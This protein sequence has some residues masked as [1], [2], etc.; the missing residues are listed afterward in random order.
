MTTVS[1]R[2][3]GQGEAPPAADAGRPLDVVVVTT[4][5]PTPAETF[6]SAR[7][8]SLLEA[9]HR[10]RVASFK[11]P[12]DGWER[13]VAER[14]LE[15]AELLPNSPSAAVSGLAA[16]VS[17]PALLG[18]ALAWL[19]RTCAGQPSHLT[20]ALAA[21]PFAFH[22]LALL[23]RDAPDVVHLEWGHYPAVIVPLV[24]W[25]GLP[26]AVS[27][28]LVAYDIYRGF[29]GT[30]TAA[31][32]ADVVRTQAQGNVADIVTA[33]GLP[34]ERIELVADGVDVA[35]IRELA[36]TTARVPGRVAVAARLVPEKG[37]DDALRAF[38]HARRACPHATLHVLGTGPAEASLRRLA[39]ELGVAD[40]VAFLGHVPHDQ[41]LSE[42][43]A[44]EA[45]LHLSH[46]ERLPNAVK[47]AMACGCVVVTTRTVGIEELVRDGQTGYL[48]DVRDHAAAGAA[49]ETALTR[50]QEHARMRAAA[51]ALVAETMDHAAS[52]R[53]LVGLWRRAL[54]ARGQGQAKAA[55]R[56]SHDAV[57]GST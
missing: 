33:T 50:P 43:A 56:G 31:H 46:M 37:V 16:A 11:A 12:A 51:A 26:C 24:R 9:G 48:V 30:R 29:P 2:E 6:A 3:R 22:L 38:A 45:L 53:K 5:F 18:R 23:E 42:L 13:L 15:R 25:R 1:Q 28:S 55:G 14:G 7:V 34:R 35:R 32:L 20:R 27:L 52:V 19:A 57:T 8:R 36:A 10:V 54:A 39:A 21:L 40:A 41:V 44:A 17:R 47:E 49:L 4:M